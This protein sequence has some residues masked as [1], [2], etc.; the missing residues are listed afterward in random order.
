VVA[1]VAADAPKLPLP[2]DV[3]AP[4][5][6]V[7]MEPPLVAVEAVPPACRH[8]NLLT[9][10]KKHPANLRKSWTRATSPKTSVMYF[11]I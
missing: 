2:V 11:P 4:L 6:P 9:K 5:P 1:G 3:E 10:N 7:I 8:T